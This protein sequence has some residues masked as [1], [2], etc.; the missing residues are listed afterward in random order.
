MTYHSCTTHKEKHK[1]TKNITLRE[2]TFED[3][4]TIYAIE[5]DAH[6]HPWTQENLKRSLTK[7]NNYNLAVENEKVIGFGIIEVTNEESQLLN[8]AVYQNHRGYGYGKL[9]LK[10]LIDQ[11]TILK[12]SL[13]FLEVRISNDTALTLYRSCGFSEVDRIV[14]YYPK[15]TRSEDAIIMA[16]E[17]T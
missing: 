8:L 9:I 7:N 1:T 6:S 2:I 16:L 4:D 14:N 15:D 3:F 10:A 5:K 13:M 17:F 12:A 11:A